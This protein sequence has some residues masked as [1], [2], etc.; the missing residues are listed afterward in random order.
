MS[1]DCAYR[2]NAV[3]RADWRVGQPLNFRVP[4]PSG[5]FEGAEGLVYFLFD[6]SDSF[7]K[8]PQFA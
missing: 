7:S 8:S 4:A 1:L 6:D 3:N 5:F 2:Q